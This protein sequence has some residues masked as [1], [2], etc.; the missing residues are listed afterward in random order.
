MLFS[1]LPAL[2][3][4]LCAH[5]QPI[6]RST[7]TVTPTYLALTP[8][9][10]EFTRFAD[11]G[12]DG[13]W[14]IGFN[15][16]WIV[17]LPQAPAGEFSHAFLGAR[18]G[19]AKTRPNPNKPWIRELIAGKVYIAISQTPAFTTE[20]SYFLAETGD[21]PLEND[22]SNSVEGVGAAEWFW[23]EVPMNMISFTRP[24]YLTVW[25]PTKYFV[26]ASSSPILAAAVV[27]D[28]GGEPVAWNNRSISGV[29][30]RVTTTA[31]ETPIPNFYPAIAI[32]LVPPTQGE[33]AITDFRFTRIGRKGL[34]EFSVAGEDVTEV[35]LESSRDQL[36]WVRASHFLRKPPFSFV[37]PAERMPPPG[38]FVRGSARDASGEIGN[39]PAV[40]IPYAGQ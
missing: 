27:E 35:W 22:P 15:N 17:K 4:A 34:A 25:S 5:A 7:S 19:R 8:S 10:N 3:L 2:F 29:P 26:R 40:Q 23:T 9:L 18:I 6:E 16:A 21:I 13:S 14:Y 33:V 20:Q 31:L 28:K 32:R 30:P 11:G 1:A 37:I 39:G 24:N 38:S 12:P 36:D